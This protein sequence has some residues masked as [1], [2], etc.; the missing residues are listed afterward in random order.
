MLCHLGGNLFYHNY[1]TESKF[2]RLTVSVLLLVC[3]IINFDVCSVL[4]TAIKT[5][6][7]YWKLQYSLNWRSYITQTYT[8]YTVHDARSENLRF[9]NLKIPKILSKF[10]N[11]YCTV[12]AC[13]VFFRWTPH[14]FTCPETCGN[15]L[16]VLGS[17][18]PFSW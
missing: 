8:L 18:N 17:L 14:W 13:T 12:F 11:T 6:C 16:N 9:G 2:Y 10:G 15:N 1:Y 4:C 7:A 3:V 5:K